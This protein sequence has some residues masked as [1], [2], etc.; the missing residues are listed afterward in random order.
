MMGSASQFRPGSQCLDLALHFNDTI[1]SRIKQRR[2]I[3]L[4]DVVIADDFTG[5]PARRR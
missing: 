5:N 1:H 4:P 2:G 3:D